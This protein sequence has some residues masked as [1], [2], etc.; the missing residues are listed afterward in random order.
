MKFNQKKIA[1]EKKEDIEYGQQFIKSLGFKSS[2]DTVPKREPK[3]SLMDELFTTKTHKCFEL[4][5]KVVNN[6][7]FEKTSTMLA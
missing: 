5:Q 2:G 6:G 1:E 7:A 4:E 3:G